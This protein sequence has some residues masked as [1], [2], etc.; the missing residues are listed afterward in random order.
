MLSD[1][2]NSSTAFRKPLAV[3]TWLFILAGL[4]L[5]SLH[6]YLLFHVVVEL[7]SIA[8]AFCVF[9]IAWNS[10][11]LI[12]NNYLL[13]VGISYLFMGCLDLAHTMSFKGMNIISV[14]TNV[15]TQ[16]WIASRYLQSI[17]LLLALFF[18][19]RKIKPD[20]VFASYLAVFILT[21]L[22]IFYVKIFPD[23]FIE[24]K[25]LTQFKINSEYLISLLFISTIVLLK[26]YKKEFDENILRLIVWSLLFAIGSELFFTLY[27]NVYG[28]ANLIGHYFKVASFYCMY[29]ATIE[30]GLE[31][32][33]SV[34]LRDLKISEK[35]LRN[36]EEE[37]EKTIKKRT[38]ELQ[39]TN[40]QIVALGRRLAEA[41]NLE[42]QRLARELHDQVGQ[43]LTALGINLNILR[44]KIPPEI[45]EA[46]NTRINDS[47][48]LIG[49]T[50]DS[51]RDV[52]AQ[53]RPPVLDDYGLLAAL[54]WHG[55]Q[56]SSRT[57]INVAIESEE[58]DPRM[59]MHVESALLRIAQEAL[60]NV[61]KHAR[62]TK[63]RITLN[64]SSEKATLVI[65]DNGIGFNANRLAEIRS[66]G[67]WGLTNI[68][69]RAVSIGG[70]CDIESKP[71]EGTRITVGVA[72]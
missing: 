35:T 57:G 2:T 7:F 70:R 18:F 31:K 59:T 50:T 22:S 13:L 36:H 56:F 66:A 72:L 38:D 26:R 33:Y 53:L 58:T 19:G 44:S 41:E 25:G 39:A 55:E 27:L 16:L 37:L 12:S 32:P 42:R 52:M 47:L 63:V 20:L 24:G 8:I 28:F 1:T 21:L 51:I 6:S 10:R 40:A 64:N 49:E 3:L 71:G 15:P 29:R 17:S 46:A 34:L 62:A 43:N 69:E 48:A 23:C 5:S 67:K 61:A 60:N 68:T 9:M 14:D 54:R 30:T 65:E 11:K 4:Y 45:S